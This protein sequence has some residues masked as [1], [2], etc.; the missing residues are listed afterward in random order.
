MALTTQQIARLV[1]GELVGPGDV[2]IASIEGIDA[3][4]PDQI[5]FV[6]DER[7]AERWAR[8]R[9]AAAIVARSLKL[10][11][12]DGQAIIY[13]DNVDSAVIRL[14]QAMAPPTTLP[15]QGVHP[16]AIVEPTARLGEGV[17]V[18]PQCYVGGGVQLGDGVVLH[19]N[20]T[21]LEG[22]SI[23]PG[24]LVWS[25]VVVRERC[26]IGA[27]CILHPNATIGADGFGFRPAAD[28]QGLVKVPQIGNVVIGD[29]VEVGAGTCVDR[30]KFGSTRIGHGVK[31]DNLCQIAHNCQIGRNVIMAAGCGVAGSVTIGDGVVLGGNVGLRDHITIGAGAKILAYAAVMNDVPPGETWGGYPAKDAKMAAR[32]YAAVRKLPEWM[33]NFRRRMPD[34]E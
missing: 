23:G 10:A 26:V 4:G 18:G 17:R 32:E 20:V 7:Y 6:T 33:K 34:G 28:G 19:P 5:T 25:G 13:V 11:P 1:G 3:A 29:D 12:T 22:C 16:S 15:A 8:C 14:L 31:I 9:G 24:T 2:A 27:R 30:A 21:V